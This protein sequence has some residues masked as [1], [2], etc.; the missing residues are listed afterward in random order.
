MKQEGLTLENDATY[1]VTMKLLSTTSRSINT[2]F[3]G[4]GDAWYGGKMVTVEAGQEKTVDY[5]FTVD[6]ETGSAI[7]F[8][9][10]MGKIADEETPA[11]K[12]TISNVSVKKK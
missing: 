8:Y 10:S 7:A 1:Q 3:I 11:G 2:G 9:I 12:V 5:T 6:K 4:T